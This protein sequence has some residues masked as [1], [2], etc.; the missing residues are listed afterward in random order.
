MVP[1][2]RFMLVSIRL[3]IIINGYQNYIGGTKSPSQNLNRGNTLKTTKKVGEAYC[4]SILSH[5]H[6]LS[7]IGSYLALPLPESNID[8]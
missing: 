4:T 2:V 8:S 3:I 7:A 5:A 6:E 1:N